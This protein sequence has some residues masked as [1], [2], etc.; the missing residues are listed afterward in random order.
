MVLVKKSGTM[1]AITKDFTKM[2]PNMVRAY[3]TGP[4]VTSISANGMKIS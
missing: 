1:A 3:I 2:E 4:T